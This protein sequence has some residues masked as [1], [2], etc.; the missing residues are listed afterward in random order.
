[1]AKSCKF[2][3]NDMKQKL[4]DFG[5]DDSHIEE[6]CDLFNKNNGHLDVIKFS[7]LLERY[8]V[9]RVNIVSFLKDIGIDDSTIIN[10][11]SKADFV[12]LGMENRDLTQVVLT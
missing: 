7:I 3:K 4:R 8:G 10:I 5:L 11:F 9:Q 1:M 6:I 12:K 2:E